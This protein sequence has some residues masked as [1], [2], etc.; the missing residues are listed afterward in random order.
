MQPLDEQTRALLAQMK[1]GGFRPAHEIPIEVS[2]AG[3][4][5]M[6]QQ[7]AGPRQPVYAIEERHIVGPGGDLPVRIYRPDPGPTTA[8]AA[9]TLY[10]HGG[11]FYLGNFDTHDHV[12]RFLCRHAGLVVVAVD[13]RLAPEHKFPAAVEDC[14]AALRWAHD[15]AAELRVDPARIAVTGDSAGATLVV[16]TCL[17]A[18]SRGGPPIAYQVA[19]YPALTMTDGEEFPSRRALGGGEYFISLA[20]FAFFRGVYLT[21][22]EREARDPLAS[23]IYAADYRGLPP[24]LV[25]TAG[26]DPCRDE[27]ERYAERLRADGV[28]VRYDC[29]ETTIH[30]FFLFDGVLDTGKAGQR[31]VADALRAALAAR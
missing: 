22:P 18:R 27:A 19:V 31:L 21:D 16:T 30:P 10:F 5:A 17:L 13:Y 29:F 28:A 11:G 26:Y 1:A 12:C 3:L 24:A 23:P 4:T 9:A 15:A 25:V 14:Y 6:A 20:D 8:P 7:M 2:R